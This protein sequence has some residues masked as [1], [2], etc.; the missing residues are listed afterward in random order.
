MQQLSPFA[1]FLVFIG[2]T[3]FTGGKLVDMAKIRGWIDGTSENV[4]YISDKYIHSGGHNGD[5]YLIS[6]TN[7]AIK[8]QGPHRIKIEKFQWENVVIG[9]PIKIV[10]LRGDDTPYLRDGIYASN[11]NFIFEIMLELLWITSLIYMLM[12]PR[13][14]FLREQRQCI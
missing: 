13:N 10:K 4:F 6:W 12:L 14:R 11:S 3:C 2:L 5:T 7:D 8:T 9:D 1:G